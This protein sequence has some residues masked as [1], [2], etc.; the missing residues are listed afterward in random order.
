M[1]CGLEFVSGFTKLCVSKS[2]H[3]NSSVEN[4]HFTWRFTRQIIR[5]NQL[6]L[7]ER[8]K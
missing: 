7:F 1:K 4:W 8:V 2:L 5:K 6:K 3:I